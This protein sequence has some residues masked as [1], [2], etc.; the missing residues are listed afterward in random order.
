MGFT[1]GSLARDIESLSDDEILANVMTSLRRI[2]GDNI[3]SP[4]S[5]MITRWNS[6][7]Y[8]HG[9]Y[10][11]VPVRSSSDY[12]SVLAEVEGRFFFAGEHTSLRDPNTVHGAYASGMSAAQQILS[13]IA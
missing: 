13:R 11:F 5:H 8:S 10:S 12:F 3:P 9:S 7:P 2:Y 1:G 4:T 6:D